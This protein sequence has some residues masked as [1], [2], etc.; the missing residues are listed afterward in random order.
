VQSD[1]FRTAL[2]DVLAASPNVRERVIFELT[3]SSAIQRIEEAAAF[4]ATLR[5]AGNRVC[6]DDF[7]AGAAAYGYLRHFEVDFVKIDGP[8]LT[9][10]VEK[11]RERA[12]IRSICQLCEDLRSETIGE[13]IEDERQSTVAAR[14]GIAY[15]QGWLFGRPGPT[16]QDPAKPQRLG[17]RK[18]YVE[19][20]E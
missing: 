12:L 19:R 16:L 7:G 3:E 2:L 11:E 20:W 15:G 4:L 6:L 13:M 5:A 8:F 1:A 9:A 17:K 14:L 18:G 10:A